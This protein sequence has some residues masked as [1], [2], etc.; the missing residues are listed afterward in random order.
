MI[1]HVPEERPAGSHNSAGMVEDPDEGF[2]LPALAY[3]SVTPVVQQGPEPEQFFLWE[4][5]L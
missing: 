5:E 2:K 4:V 3:F 1:E